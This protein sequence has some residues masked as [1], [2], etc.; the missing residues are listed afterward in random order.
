MIASTAR[1]IVAVGL[2][3]TLSTEKRPVR[4]SQRPSKIIP[5]F[6]PARTFAIACSSKDL[7]VDDF[8][9]IVYRHLLTRIGNVY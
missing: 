4:I 9:G 7:L 1:P 3:L 6:L 8:R 5:M 2:S